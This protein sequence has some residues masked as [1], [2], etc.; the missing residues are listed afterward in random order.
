M[1][2]DKK[3]NYPS[4]KTPGVYPSGSIKELGLDNANL[5]EFSLGSWEDISLSNKRF[6]YQNLFSQ[7]PAQSFINPGLTGFIKDELFGFAFV[8]NENNTPVDLEEL[9]NKV[10][11]IAYNYLNKN[12]SFIESSYPVKINFGIDFIKEET[13]EEGDTPFVNYDQKFI[14]IEEGEEFE[15]SNDVESIDTTRLFGLYINSGA[16]TDKF[17]GDDDDKIIDYWNDNWNIGYLNDKE[18]GNPNPTVIQNIVLNHEDTPFVIKWNTFV[19]PSSEGNVGS[20]RYA[21]G[22][23]AY[24]IEFT[25]PI[26]K[27]EYPIK[28]LD[29]IKLFSYWNH[30]YN[31]IDIKGDEN[32]IEAIQLDVVYA[33]DIDADAFA[34]D[35]G[36]LGYLA[37]EDW[38]DA[39]AATNKVMYLPAPFELRANSGQNAT[40]FDSDDVYFNDQ[41]SPQ[42]GGESNLAEVYTWGNQANEVDYRAASQYDGIP[43]LRS[44]DMPVGYEVVIR[45]PKS[46]IAESNLGFT[47]LK[48]EEDDIKTT[49]GDEEL[50]LFKESIP[51]S[52]RKLSEDIPPALL[53]KVYDNGNTDDELIGFRQPKNN[54]SGT[55]DDAVAVS[56]EDKVENVTMR[57]RHGYYKSGLPPSRDNN[58]RG[59]GKEYSG[60]LGNND[61]DRFPILSIRAPNS[62]NDDADGPQFPTVMWRKDSEFVLY[63][64]D[65]IDNI[66][67]VFV[68]NSTFRIKISARIYIQDE[69]DDDYNIDIGV[70]VLD[71]SSDNNENGIFY[72]K[73]LTNSHSNTNLGPTEYTH[74]VNLQFNEWIDIELYGKVFAP[75]SPANTLT[76]KPYITINSRQKNIKDSAN[77]RNANDFITNSNHR[78]YFQVKEINLEK[79][80]VDLGENINTDLL[81]SGIYKYQ[82]IQWGDEKQKLTNQQ[83]LNS[84]HFNWY[85]TD[86]PSDWNLKKY[87]REFARTDS[88][89]KNYDTVNDKSYFNLSPHVY[90]TPGLKTIKTIVY[91]TDIQITTVLESKLITT[92]IL[93]NDGLFTS[94]DFSIFSGADFN[95]L[96]LDKN[97]AIIGGFDGESK[98][99]NSVSKIVK[100]DNFIQDDYLERVSSRD[101]IEKFNNDFLGK[102][103]GQ[104]DL[105]QTRVFTEP[106]DIYDFIGANKLEW[107]NQKSGSLPINSLATD[108][109]IRDDKCVV[110]LDPSN[111]EYSAIQNQAG[112]EEIGILIGDYKVNQPQGG[113]IQKE[114]TMETPLLETDNKKQAF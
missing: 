85:N 65:K 41:D 110:D 47:K 38:L 96:P 107:I 99:H 112:S 50:S 36:I 109:F 70:G 25:P 54:W 113:R 103:P 7:Q 77:N 97:Q 34:Q 92:N 73:S 88:F 74:D 68:P 22:N 104:L 3:D 53:E 57:A 94:Q 29:R 6:I 21:L 20:R 95:F 24:R 90:N 31:V 62:I 83:L 5:K 42:F 13:Q 2:Y 87:F 66:L 64:S 51:R 30:E 55:G 26:S 108:I 60:N 28:V 89:I 91:R 48:F 8:Q 75:I 14:E 67:D 37:G 61:N 16:G 39:N 9:E 32:E 69:S 114:S 10:K 78:F 18:P 102:Q 33:G 111:S 52:P 45:R 4:V 101:Y 11:P 71:L 49:D 63:P 105:G 15:I 76:G 81:N 23:G 82:V 1:A 12:N 17:W 106:K 86:N 35:S 43:V 40:S 58:N 84:F 72:T 59:D 19:N 44:E 80:E 56:S 46:S 79:V 93:I 98:Y 100:D 27:T